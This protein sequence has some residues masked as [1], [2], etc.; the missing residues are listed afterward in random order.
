MILAPLLREEKVG[1]GE[2][3]KLEIENKISEKISEPE[4][5]ELEPK[6]VNKPLGR[7][8][9]SGFSIKKHLDNV[10][11]EEEKSSVRTNEELPSNHFSDTDLQTEWNIFLKKL[12]LKN[13]VTFNA[14]KTFKLKKLDE[15]LV[16][17]SYPSASAKKEFESVESDFFNNFRNKV[18]NFKIEVSY[19][20]DE[21]LKKEVITKRKLF[22][23]FVEINPVLKDLEDLMKFDLS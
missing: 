7:R 19:K 12:A 3:K 21:R 11:N 1:I 14:I 18:H 6:K 17:I 22:E 20:N 5:Q 10:D 4:T 13:I 15:N 8:S 23:K 2:K 9:G 16:E